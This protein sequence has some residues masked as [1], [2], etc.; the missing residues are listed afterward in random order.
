MWTM[1]ATRKRIKISKY[2]RSVLT[3]E[4][5]ADIIQDKNGALGNIQPLPKSLNESKGHRSG[6]ASGSPWNNAL[7]QPV[8]PDYKKALDEA[9]KAI[10][11]R[12]EREIKRYQNEN[13][14]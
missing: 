12:I 7:G 8:H 10:T 4:Q 14:R 11:S 6:G 2:P 13:A 3:R 1:T 9:D 5:M